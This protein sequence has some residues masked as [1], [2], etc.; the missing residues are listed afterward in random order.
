MSCRFS[1]FNGTCQL[2]DPEIENFG[3]NSEGFCI[4]EDNENPGYVCEEYEER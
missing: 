2:Y 3:W 1:D 4:C